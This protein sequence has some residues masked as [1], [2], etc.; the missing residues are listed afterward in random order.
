M[1]AVAASGMVSCTKVERRCTWRRTRWGWRRSR[2]SRSCWTISRSE[3]REER[4][5]KGRRRDCTCVG[6]NE[7][8]SRLLPAA[9]LCCFASSP[10]WKSLARAPL[11]RVV[12]RGARREEKRREVG[13][14]RGEG[15]RR[16]KAAS[17]GRGGENSAE[18]RV[19]TG[20]TALRNQVHAT[21]LVVHSVLKG[22]CVCLI[23]QPQCSVCCP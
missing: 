2:S 12:G 10:P 13:E 7:G 5:R 11:L 14:E 3:L 23:S 19:R 20:A 21:A 4:G 17:Q 8:K 22:G 15:E 9:C 1:P 16:G 6:K 18:R